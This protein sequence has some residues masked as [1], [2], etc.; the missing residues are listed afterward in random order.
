MEVSQGI[1]IV[2]SAGAVC[3]VVRRGGVWVVIGCVGKGLPCVGPC[4]RVWVQRAC[5]TDRRHRGW[6]DSAGILP[7]DSV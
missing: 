6:S 7:E 1:I 5:Q 4:V 2:G 3:S